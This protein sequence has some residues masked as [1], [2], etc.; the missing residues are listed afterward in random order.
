MKYSFFVFLLLMSQLI[1]AQSMQFSQAIHLSSEESVYAFEGNIE[2]NLVL[3]FLDESGAYTSIKVIDT[4]LKLRAKTSINTLNLSFKPN[5]VNLLGKYIVVGGS[6]FNK[7]KFTHTAKCAVL[8]L[9]LQLIEEKELGS[10]VVNSNANIGKFIFESSSNNQYLY[11]LEE[12]PYEKGED[13]RINLHQFQGKMEKGFSKSFN[14][15]I[16]SH[17][18]QHNIPFVANNGTVFIG[19]GHRSTSGQ[20]Y[21]LLAFNPKSQVFK[22]KEIKLSDGSITQLDFAIEDNNRL[23]V[24]GLFSTNG[25]AAQGLYIES[26]DENLKSSMSITEYFDEETLAF[27]MDKKEL[28]NYGG[29]N[30]YVIEKVTVS[31]DNGVSVFIEQ[32]NETV[33]DDKK[34]GGKNWNYT[35][36]KVLIYTYSERGALRGTYVMDKEQS[37]QNDNAFWSSIA[38][39]NDQEDF[40]LLTNVMDLKMVG[41]PKLNLIH[42]KTD[43]STDLKPLALEKGYAFSPESYFQQ[44]NSFFFIVATMDKKQIKVGKLSN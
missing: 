42:Y 33:N 31:N 34:T 5:S 11:V 23:A 18:S 30:N 6:S 13:Q 16:E 26:Y 27:A 20:V 44:A 1:Q 32:V 25:Y 37:T 19:K 29:L 38:V 21:H 8:D 2:G 41:E 24:A 9:S 22:I 3:S 35:Y 36:G 14:T 17:K 43:N 39:W 7:E 12:A 40:K 28:K 15:K 10:M 4:N